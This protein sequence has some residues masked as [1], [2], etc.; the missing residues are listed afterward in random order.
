MRFNR[1]SLESIT[2]FPNTLTEGMTEEER[3]YTLGESSDN[4]EEQQEADLQ[5]QETEEVNDRIEE[6]SEEVKTGITSIESII[7]DLEAAMEPS[8]Q[9]NPFVTEHQVA[10]DV[11]LDDDSKA[12]LDADVDA[13]IQND[14]ETFESLESIKLCNERNIP[15]LIEILRAKREDLLKAK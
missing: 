1:A 6:L 14:P 4:L 10:I 13:V 9:S 3:E 11:E 2:T 15:T 12:T 8:D 5:S 7:E